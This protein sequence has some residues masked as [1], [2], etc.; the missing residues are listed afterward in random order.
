M[1]DSS[2]ASVNGFGGADTP[3]A[4][5][6]EPD[7]GR[8]PFPSESGIR[9]MGFLSVSSVFDVCSMAVQPASMV[10]S[11]DADNATRSVEPSA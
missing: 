6:G 11:L 9:F 4:R 1:A 3:S 5:E 2:V 7:W 10:T 8:G